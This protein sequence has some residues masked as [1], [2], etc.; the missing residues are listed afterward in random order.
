MFRCKDDLSNTDYLRL[1]QFLQ[2]LFIA[3]ACFNF[4]PSVCHFNLDFICLNFYF[5]FSQKSALFLSFLFLILISADHI[6]FPFFSTLVPLYLLRAFSF[7]YS[8]RYHVDF[9]Y[10][11]ISD[12][13][14]FQKSNN[15]SSVCFA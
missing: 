5:F 2:F 4:L 10:P 13:S 9:L 11:F 8:L 6:V 7:S 12:F 15:L 3:F 1:L 14:P